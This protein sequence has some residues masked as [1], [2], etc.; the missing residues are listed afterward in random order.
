[1]KKL[2]AKLIRLLKEDAR[3]TAEELAAMVGESAET[4]K[5]EIRA[6]ED[7]GVIVKYTAI[8]NSEIENENLVEAL[9]EVRVTPKRL[10]GFD[11]IAEEIN[12]FKEVRSLYLMSGGSFSISWRVRRKRSSRLAWAIRTFPPRGKSVT[13]G[14]RSSCAA[15][16]IILRTSVFRNSAKPFRNI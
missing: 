9:I 5:A 6:L 10:K 1:M 13:R 7:D 11:A 15:E 12:R 2:Q 8:T 16:R 4:V 14:R 3:Y